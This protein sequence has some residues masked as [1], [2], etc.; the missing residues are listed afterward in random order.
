MLFSASAEADLYSV[1]SRL[2]PPI[3]V[4]LARSVRIR[5][6]NTSKKEGVG[7][8]EGLVRRGLPL[9]QQALR[10]ELPVELREHVLVCVFD[11][12]MLMVVVV[13]VVAKVTL[14]VRYEKR[15]TTLSSVVWSCFSVMRTPPFLSSVSV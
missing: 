8:T 14:S 7:W 3:S 11:E 6:Q 13:V 12:G 15:R 9:Q 10:E 2:S 5:G 4:T 1:W